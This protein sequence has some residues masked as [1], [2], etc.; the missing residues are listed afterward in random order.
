MQRRQF[1]HATGLGLAAPTLALQSPAA[2]AAM[3]PL[4]IGFIY[5]GPVA[6]VG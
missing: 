6:D 1:L 2:R 3:P 4:K 5:S